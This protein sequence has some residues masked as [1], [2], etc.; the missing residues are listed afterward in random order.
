MKKIL[1][2]LIA[3]VLCLSLFAGCAEKE[4][5]LDKKILAKIGDYE[6]SQ[7]D[8]NCHYYIIYNTYAQY[9]QYFGEE[10]IDTDL[11]EGITIGETMKNEA[12]TQIEQFAA[13]TIIAK[14]RYGITGKDV[15]NRVQ[16][17][18]DELIESYGGKSTFEKDLLKP[19]QMTE[20][21][22]KTYFEM[23][24]IFA[25]LTEKM[26]EEGGELQVT[27]EEIEEMLQNYPKVSHIL[28][29]TK[30]ADGTTPS[31]SDEEAMAIVNE[32]YKKLKNGESFEAL[33][34]QYGE[35]PGM[36][37]N[38]YYVCGYGEM[39]PEFE[40]ASASL[41]IDEYTKTPVKSD[42]GYHIIKRYAY[43]SSS[44]EYKNAKLTLVQGKLFPIIETEAEKLET[45][46][47]NEAIEKNTSEWHKKI[48]ESSANE[49][50]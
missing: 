24:E 16:T 19:A 45:K 20:K 30:S 25:L 50:E 18:L 37:T 39:V 43:D 41:K 42:Y 11:G 13:A 6:I 12:K 49:N 33:I 5:A 40:E 9:S 22:L 8:Y 7:A 36:E 4:N 31:R 10:W 14:D 32:V 29:S 47:D 48:N 34:A 21:S 44:E 23:Y 28:I 46:W 3:L 1:A 15:K 2:I 38:D 17:D 26:A 27:D 35:D